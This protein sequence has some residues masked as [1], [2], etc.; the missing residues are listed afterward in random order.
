MVEYIVAIDVTRVRFPADASYLECD[1]VLS[2]KKQSYVLRAAANHPKNV[3]ALHFEEG[4]IRASSRPEQ[5]ILDR[6]L[7]PMSKIFF[8]KIP[9]QSKD[10]QKENLT[11]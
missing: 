6:K 7:Q 11:P 9:P 10:F 4:L 1:R 2:I 8:R 5:R 3:E